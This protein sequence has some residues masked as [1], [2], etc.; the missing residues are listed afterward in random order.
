[1]YLFKTVHFAEDVDNLVVHVTTG[2]VDVCFGGPFE[3]IER[4]F[5]IGTVSL[6][7]VEDEVVVGVNSGEV[8]SS[9]DLLC[10]FVSTKFKK[11]LDE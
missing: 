9:F 2:W 10:R 6:Q 1:M 4:G 11:V 3:E 7:D 8:E 5:P